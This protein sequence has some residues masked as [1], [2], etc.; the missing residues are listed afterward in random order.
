MH[1]L[2]IAIRVLGM[3]LAMAW[4]GAQAAPDQSPLLTRTATPPAP[5]VMITIDDSG[6]MQTNFIPEGTQTVNGKSVTLPSQY[7]PLRFYF[8]DV[9]YGDP[10]HSAYGGSSGTIPASKTGAT[11]YE[12]QMRSSSVNRIYYD[13]A[14][15]YRPWYDP[16]STTGAR[17]ADASASA[18]YWDPANPGLGTF[19]LTTNYVVN[20]FGGG[21]V[22]TTWWTAV[23]TSVTERRDWY[24]GT[25]YVLTAG[26]D[27]TSTSTSSYTRYDIND[28]S[29]YSPSTKAAT[30]TDCAG[31]RCTKAE[32]TK[33]FA[34]WFQY[35]RSRILLTKAAISEVI[36]GSTGNARFGLGSINYGSGTVK[37]IDIDNF[38]TTHRNKLLKEV[39]GMSAANGTPLK[40]AI[41]AIGD[42]F[43]TSTPW[44]S[45]STST[46]ILACRRAYNVLMTDG[47]YN[48]GSSITPGNVD[49]TT[50][51]EHKLDLTGLATTPPKGY[52][53]AAPYSDSVSNTL[54]DYAMT[55]YVDDLLT[56]VENKVVPTSG[57][58]AD[59]AYWQHLSQFTVGLGVVGT[60]PASTE[61]EKADTLSK[62][63]SGKLSWPDPGTDGDTILAQKIDDLWHA[64][65]NTRGDFFL[66]NNSSELTAALNKAIGRAAEASRSEGGVVSSSRSASTSA[67]KFQPSYQAGAWWGDLK[68]FK[69]Y[70]STSGS[71]EFDTTELWSANAMV[72]AAASRN[73][74]TWT[75]T[76][77]AAFDTSLSNTLKTLIAPSATQDSVINYLRGDTTNEG[78]GSSNFRQRG[79]YR[80]ADFV[81]SAPTYVKGLLDMGYSY[82]GY[83]TFVTSKKARSS[84]VVFIGGNGGMLHGFRDSDGTEVVAYVP[85]SVY[86]KL[87]K[88]TA[89][90]YGSTSNFHQAYV[91]G[92]ITEV[93]AYIATRK[94]TTAWANLIIGALGAGGTGLY[95][96]DVTDLSSFNA[97]NVMWEVSAT[98]NA[99]IGYIFNRPAVGRLN[100]K[101]YAFFG[102][103]A[104][105]TNGRSVLFAVNLETGALRNLVLDSSSGGGAMG[106]TLISNP[107]TKDVLGA[108]VGDLKGNLWRVDMAS[109]A[110]ADWKIGFNGKPLFIARD[111]SGN[112]QPITVPPSTMTHYKGG[113]MVLFGT[114]RLIDT[115]DPDSKAVQSYYGVWDATA[116]G[117]SAVTTTDPAWALLGN[118]RSQLQLQ[119]IRASAQA[120]YW[121]MSSNPVDWTTQRGWY[122]DLTLPKESSGQR[123]LYPSVV[124]GEFVM[125][126]TVVPA[127]APAACTTTDGTGFNFLVP[128]LTGGMY[129][130]PTLDT[131]GDG[132]IS[133]ESGDVVA[134][135]YTTAADGSDLMMFKDSDSGAGGSNTSGSSSTSGT[136]CSTR[137]CIDWRTYCINNGCIKSRVWRQLLN[138]PQ[139]G[140]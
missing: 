18:V 103:G 40:N 67:L 123:V 11:V 48:G 14:V 13:P 119:T 132:V 109:D 22:Y 42:Y 51:A 10:T 34:N 111:E 72:P 91:D 116:V 62:I 110:V 121:E 59:P 68:A 55:Y 43:K 78:T 7:N 79:G 65:V 24:P 3:A 38:S 131:N 32:E 60:L 74:L 6:S 58:L 124:L 139:P 27:P 135:G 50:G 26:A 122:M 56:D 85:K 125:I 66:A 12:M 44:Y 96:L 63:K 88:L 89:Q 23:D 33:N 29:S 93:D 120:G 25:Y 95:A 86:G 102:N 118:Q 84:G 90:D 97:N 130:K 36:G 115:G 54:A 76:A 82:T 70:K 108:Y 61:A 75:G 53:P 129:S 69:A 46:E 8:Q 52:V 92:P 114:G 71:L 30:R 31:T 94:N 57:S 45:S 113:T 28:S 77:G 37:R 5:N 9:A 81:N 133:A 19:D 2:P 104:S 21:G 1:Q 106:V 64:A 138:P 47:Y 49:N 35:Y 140:S 80:L 98:D 128:G 41:I 99:D 112:L 126:Y 39:Q 20:R 17:L 15:V 73:I 136:N 83:S 105:S 134:A 117:A 101:W 137:D 4:L 87:I 16:S 107:T 100:G 127:A